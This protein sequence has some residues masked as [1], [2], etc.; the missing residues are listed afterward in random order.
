[1]SEFAVKRKQSKKATFS[2]DEMILK[3]FNEIAK[4]MKYNKS[5]TVTNLMKMFI[6]QEKAVISQ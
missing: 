3:E 6:K 5:E 2:I 4:T 1:M